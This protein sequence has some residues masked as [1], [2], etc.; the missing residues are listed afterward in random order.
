MGSMLKALA[1]GKELGMG[2]MA[3]SPLVYSEGEGGRQGNAC[4]HGGLA[5][6]TGSGTF[7][8]VGVLIQPISS[9]F[10]TEPVGR[11]SSSAP[12]RQWK[13]S[14]RGFG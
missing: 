3:K 2:S 8:I 1:L 9:F 7:F 14:R 5:G 13:S 12:R 10:V 6:R 4:M 11:P